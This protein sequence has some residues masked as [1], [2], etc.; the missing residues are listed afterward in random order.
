MKIG[1]NNSVDNEPKP[2][3]PSRK[4]PRWAVYSGVCA[5]VIFIF[6]GVSIGKP[7]SK[8][9]GTTEDNSSKAVEQTKKS[10]GKATS[11]A[12]A[13]GKLGTVKSKYENGINKGNNAP[14]VN[15]TVDM[16]SVIAKAMKIL[17]NYSSSSTSNSSRAD[18]LSQYMTESALD[19]LIPEDQRT[20]KAQ[21]TQSLKVTYKTTAEPY[22]TAHKGGEY[23][24]LVSY[25]ATAFGQSQDRKDSYK[26]YTN[27]NKI[28]KIESD[29]SVD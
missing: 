6:V 25:S 11:N 9:K 26:V 20:A 27:H 13:I 29:G 8:P 23:D 2:E 16:K 19:T 4:L 12:V 17:Y 3:A 14:K 7:T 21:D 28:I 22:I 5:I 24:V 1:S 10:D 15:N 18:K